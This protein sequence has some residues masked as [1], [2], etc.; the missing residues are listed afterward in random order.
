MAEALRWADGRAI[1]ELDIKDAPLAAVLNMVRDLGAQE[2]VVII[3][4]NLAEAKRIHNLAPDVMISAPLYDQSD[5]DAILAQ[6]VPPGNLL[7]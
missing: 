5:L 6:G 4:D 2:E 1:V 3:A 7:A